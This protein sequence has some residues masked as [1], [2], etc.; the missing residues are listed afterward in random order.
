MTNVV[1]VTNIW[2]KL[3]SV[4]RKVTLIVTDFWQLLSQIFGETV[5]VSSYWCDPVNPNL[6][7]MLRI[8]SQR[9]ECLDD[10]IHAWLERGYGERLLEK[11]KRGLVLTHDLIVFDA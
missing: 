11:R 4:E 10:F 9:R 2:Q 3:S 7:R 6:L 8:F 1:I 5:L